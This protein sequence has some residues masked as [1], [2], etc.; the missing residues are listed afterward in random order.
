MD[1][2][3]LRAYLAEMIGTFAFVF[4][5]AG[6]QY[7]AR[8][9]G[10][11]PGDVWWQPGLVWVALASGLM[12]AAVLAVT[13]PVSGGYLNPAVTIMLWVFRR[14][15]E[16][17]AIFLV[18][19]QVLGAAIAGAA[20]WLVLPADEPARMASHLGAPYLNLEYFGAAG[21]SST[22]IWMKGVALE[23]IL[24]FI[25]VIVIFGTQLDPRA[26]RW[27]GNWANRLACLWIGLA[28][29]GCTIFGFPFTGA[30]LNPARWLGPALWDLTQHADA[31]QY[32]APYWL[33]PIAGT[34]LAGW[35]YT[36][37]VLPPEVE[38]RPAAA[39]ATPTARP[40]AA[41][42]TLFRAKK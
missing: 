9:G 29:V 37:L 2:K 18:L 30:A 15:D 1:E 17:Q 34:L 16:T 23:L 3:N 20:L 10:W 27:S 35:L 33:G 12:Y 11:Q 13:V 7:V 32:H 6:S 21:S 38:T 26:S 40:A 24:T 19:A 41:S 5:S 39:A 8:L 42:S 4:I 28:L 31:F 25:L 22:G 14:L 36:A